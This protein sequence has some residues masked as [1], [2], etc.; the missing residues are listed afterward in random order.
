MRIKTKVISGH[1]DQVSFN[2]VAKDQ[3][4]GGREEGEATSIH[5][6]GQNLVAL[7]VQQHTTTE[8]ITAVTLLPVHENIQNYSFPTQKEI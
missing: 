5:R 7:Q 4:C 3:Y 1:S 2:E 8:A 6:V